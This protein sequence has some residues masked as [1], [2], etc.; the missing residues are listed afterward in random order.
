LVLLA[1]N[2][3]NF[4]ALGRFSF[5]FKTLAFMGVY[6]YTIYLIHAFAWLVPAVLI[7]NGLLPHR[8]YMDSLFVFPV[9]IAGGY[10]ASKLVEQP[11]LRLRE[12]RFPAATRNPNVS[13]GTSQV[14]AVRS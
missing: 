13:P 7:R 2:N 1:A 8:T 9:S 3:P 12:K 10:L 11:F 4:G 14:E 5:L 6:S